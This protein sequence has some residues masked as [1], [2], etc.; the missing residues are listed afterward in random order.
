MGD[1][2]Q[3]GV[4]ELSAAL[5]A[6][7]GRTARYSRGDDEWDTTVILGRTA[8]EVTNQYGVVLS[9]AAVDVLIAAAD[10]PVDVPALG[11]RVVVDECTY[12]VLAVAD[13]VWRWT[14][15]YR[16][17]VRIHTKQVE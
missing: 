12:E 4:Q 13:E 15:A 5:V 6:H 8:Y 9:A 7:A 3:I 14:D 2:L 1:L 11:D 17:M 16:T 10:L